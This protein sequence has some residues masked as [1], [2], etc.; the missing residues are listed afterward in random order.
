[1]TRAAAASS[2][3]ERLPRGVA[4]GPF[5]L[6]A[7]P[8]R[9]P[10]MPRPAPAGWPAGPPPK[11]TIADLAAQ[12]RALGVTARM[13]T[14]AGPDRALLSLPQLTIWATRRSLYWTHHDQAVTWPAGDVITA[15]RH[16][17]QLTRPSLPQPTPP[18]S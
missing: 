11:H 4:P 14:A 17:A 5:T 16:I 15:A 1:M 8:P 18:A 13:Y 3:T 12:L 7:S 10:L 2:R 6:P 9:G